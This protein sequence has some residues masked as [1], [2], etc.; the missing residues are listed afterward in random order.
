MTV[1]SLLAGNLAQITQLEVVGV[2]ANSLEVHCVWVIQSHI[3]MVIFGVQVMLAV[4]GI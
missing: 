2:G 1:S 4:F 3:E